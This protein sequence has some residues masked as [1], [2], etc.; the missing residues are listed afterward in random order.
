M[1]DLKKINLIKLE[2]SHF[3]LHKLVYFW[4]W[5]E[6][7]QIIGGFWQTLAQTSVKPS[8]LYES[9]GKLCNFCFST[10]K[11]ILSTLQD[12]VKIIKKC[13]M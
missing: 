5:N 12:Y 4:A 13:L 2:V 10:E 11:E 6:Q 3:P 9:L 7:K 1:E 8:I